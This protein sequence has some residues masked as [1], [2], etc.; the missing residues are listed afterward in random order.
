M[1]WPLGRGTTKRGNG[2]QGIALFERQMGYV[3]SRYLAFTA[4]TA[5]SLK[6]QAL[7]TWLTHIQT[8]SIPSGSEPTRLSQRQVA[9]MFGTPCW[10]FHYDHRLAYSV[11]TK[12]LPSTMV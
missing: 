4:A 7:R 3:R 5:A 2:E 10:S 8:Y 1:A 9:A 12:S 11:E 6:P